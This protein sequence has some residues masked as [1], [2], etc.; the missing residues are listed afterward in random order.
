MTK[1]IY[2][3]ICGKNAKRAHSPE[4]VALLKEFYEKFGEQK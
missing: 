1:S 4:Y 3:M 2:C